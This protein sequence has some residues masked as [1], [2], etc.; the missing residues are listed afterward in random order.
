MWFVFR[1]CKEALQDRQSQGRGTQLE[2]TSWA[3]RGH[4][5]NNGSIKGSEDCNLQYISNLLEGSSPSEKRQLLNHEKRIKMESIQQANGSS[6]RTKPQRKA[7]R[8]P[9]PECSTGQPMRQQP[10]STGH[11]GPNLLGGGHGTGQPHGLTGSSDSFAF[12]RSSPLQ[13]ILALSLLNCF[14]NAHCQ[15]SEVGLC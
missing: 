11:S 7:V 2:G 6:G 12:Q 13:L 14:P 15:S 3:P 8:E 5:W 1:T 10:A 9:G 4:I